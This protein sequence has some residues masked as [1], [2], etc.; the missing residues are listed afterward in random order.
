[1][2]KFKDLDSQELVFIKQNE[3]NKLTHWTEN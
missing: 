2:H 3:I 1:M